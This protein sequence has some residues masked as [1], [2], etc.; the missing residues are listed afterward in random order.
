M[1]RFDRVSIEWEPER[2][3][4]RVEGNYH[5]DTP[6]D[7]ENP[8]AGIHTSPG[9]VD[10]TREIEIAPP[11]LRGPLR[12]RG[13]AAFYRERGGVGPWVLELRDVFGRPWRLTIEIGAEAMVPAPPAA[14]AFAQWLCRILGGAGI[15]SDIAERLA[16]TIIAEMAAELAAVSDYAAT[17]GEATPYPTGPNLFGVSPAERIG[18]LRRELT[19]ARADA[20]A[21]R[22]EARKADAARVDQMVLT[23]VM[24]RR[25]QKAEGAL[26]KAKAQAGGSWGSRERRQ[27]A[28]ER[29]RGMAAVEKAAKRESEKE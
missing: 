27:E 23:K 29:D 16:A 2:G 3:P 5:A 8:P 26:Q 24:H 22:E 15:A 9:R 20:R 4:V 10:F 17:L 19:A 12:I 25:A 18:A 21:A 13:E 28:E 11:H 14:D 7:V 6:E 1:L